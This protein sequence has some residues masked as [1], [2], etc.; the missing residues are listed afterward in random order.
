MEIDETV[1]TK[2][3]YHKG[4]SEADDQWFFGGIER[5]TGRCFIVP[6]ARRDKDTL[7]PIIQKYICPGATIVSD[8]WASYNGIDKL[9]ELYTH[10][11]VNHSVKFVD[12][13]TGQHTNTIEST[14]QKFKSG[15]KK[16]FDA[17]RSLFATYLCDFLWRREFK[18]PDVLFHFWSQVAVLYPV[19]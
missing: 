10:Y 13:D 17:H 7:L 5:G 3:K 16:R 18:G 8:C 6:V 11:R 19:S 14:W 15:H 12:S 4:K 9:P 2:P 1:L